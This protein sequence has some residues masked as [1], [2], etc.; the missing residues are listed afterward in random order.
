MLCSQGLEMDFEYRLRAPRQVTGT[1]PPMLIL[2]HGKGANEDDLF[3][4][5]QHFDDAFVVLS[6]RAPHEMAPGYYRWYERTDSPTG[7]VFDEAEVLRSRMFLIQS[8]KDAVMA[9]GADPQRVFVLG[10]SQ[11]GA[12]ALTVAL[13]APQLVRGVVSMAGRLLPA[14]APFA[15]EPEALAH[16]TVLLQHGSQDEVVPASESATACNLFAEMRVKQALKEYPAGHTV[17]P[18]MLKDAKEFLATQLAAL[19]GTAEAA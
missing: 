15:K 5:E 16:L 9:T 7:S 8:I 14:I 18:G 1:R 11:G 10:F 6:V 13:T 4:L 2:L 17:T 19:S 12:M 3:G